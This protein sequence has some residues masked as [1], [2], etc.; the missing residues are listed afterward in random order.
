MFIFS[1]T[2]RCCLLND[3]FKY[4]FKCNK[5][6]NTHLIVSSFVANKNFHKHLFYTYSTE[7]PNKQDRFKICFKTC[8]IFFSKSNKKRPQKS[9]KRGSKMFSK[10]S[11]LKALDQ[12][13]ILHCTKRTFS[14]ADQVNGDYFYFDN[15][16]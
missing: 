4:L 3:I 2:Y 5:V 9:A 6:K 15:S 8:G 12:L 16:F 13:N 7:H 10:M 11:S 14:R 1:I